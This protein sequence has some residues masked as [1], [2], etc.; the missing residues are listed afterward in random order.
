[1]QTYSNHY[2]KNYSAYE[3]AGTFKPGA[4]PAKDSLTVTGD[5][6]TAVGPIF[7]MQEMSAGFNKASRDWKYTMIM[8]DGKVIGAT[9]GKNAA[10]MTFCYECHNG[11]APDQDAV[12]LLPEKF[13]VK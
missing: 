10:A 2:A 12:M 8:P 4:L 5:G 11:V 6:K 3:K 7:L 9:G 13:C 1:M